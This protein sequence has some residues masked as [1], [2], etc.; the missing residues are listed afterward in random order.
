MNTIT[1]DSPEAVKALFA[2]IATRSDAAREAIAFPPAANQRFVNPFCIP[3]Q[4]ALKIDPFHRMAAA[5][6]RA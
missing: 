3:E 6:M 4:L 2:E 1:D 5:R